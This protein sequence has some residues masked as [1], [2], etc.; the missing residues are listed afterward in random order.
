MGLLLQYIVGTF[1]TVGRRQ[2]NEDRL[3]VVEDLN[4]CAGDKA[5]PSAPPRAFFG[6]YDGHGG[7]S[8]SDYC[9]EELHNVSKTLVWQPP[10]GGHQV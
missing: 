1:Q 2:H 6:C 4:A 9:R 10:S 8:C 7:N 3:K 5:N